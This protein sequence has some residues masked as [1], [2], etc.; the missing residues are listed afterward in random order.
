M[1]RRPLFGFF[2]T[3]P[4]SHNKRPLGRWLWLVGYEMPSENPKDSNPRAASTRIGS[5]TAKTLAGQIRHDLRR[6]PQPSYIDMSRAHLNRV[7]VEPDTPTQMRKICEDRRSA[8]AT[9]RAMKS[10][11]AVGTRG[12]ITFG[13]DAAQLFDALTPDAQDRALLDLT[14]AIAVRLSTSVHGLVLHLDEATPHAHFTLAA[15]NVHGEPL[16][17]TTS[18]RVLSQLQDL[19]AE[20][21]GRHC[22]GIERGRAY[23]ERLAAGA[24]FAETVH[25]SVKELH[26]TLPADLQAKR[27]KVAEM[28]ELERAAASR[29]EEMQERVRKLEQK[30]E[31]SEKEVKRLQTY[32]KRLTDRLEELR[33]AQ[34]AS[35]AARIEAERIADLAH[36]ARKAHEDQVVKISAKVE[37][38]ADAVSALSEEVQAGTIRKGNDGR[39]T[40]AKPEKLKPGFPEIRPA[41]AA[42]A[43]LVTRMNA[44]RARIEAEQKAL[45]RGRQELQQERAEVST[46]REQLKAALRKVYAW[47]RRKETPEPDRRD[48]VDLI[49][50]STLLIRSATEKPRPEAGSDLDGPGF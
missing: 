7:L 19:T 24:H 11:A 37:A 21:L 46:L 10:N 40:A 28:A 29:V 27:A 17:K 2:T 5:A 26:R 48:G 23:G 4:D 44:A 34:S 45:A 42:A 8:R 1:G 35:E 38:I 18:P 49:K 3:S 50:A 32:E 43:D 16:A 9:M 47:I 12:I 33:E 25:R 22:P 6:G 14:D 31:L 30:S 39:I 41:V 15:Y 36:S 20:I 13:S